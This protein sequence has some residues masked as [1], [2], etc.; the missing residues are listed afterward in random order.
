M[1]VPTSAEVVCRAAACAVTLTVSVTVPTVRLTSRFMTVAVLIL[2]GSCENTLK[3]VLVTV[4]RYR[5]GATL[6]TE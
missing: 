1:T 6:E 3:P 5:P 4:I 2:T